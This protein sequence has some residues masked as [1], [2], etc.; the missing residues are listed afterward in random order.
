MSFRTCP[1]SALPAAAESE[2]VPLLSQRLTIT[3]ASRWQRHYAA[4]GHG[5]VYQGRFKSFPVQRDGH[6]LTVCRYV[7]RNP[8]RAGLVRRAEKWRWSSLWRRERGTDE[9][10]RILCDW[11]VERPRNWLQLVNESQDDAELGG[12]RESIARNRPFGSPQWLRSTAAKLGLGSS[13]RP[14]HRPP[15]KAGDAG[16]R[17]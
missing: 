13:L 6:S 7:E 17:A 5:H 9:Q 12:L 11:P 1:A 16:R 15:K 3:H 14:P 2:P 4:A 8:L 10:R